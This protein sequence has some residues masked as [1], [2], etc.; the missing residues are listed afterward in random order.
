MLL[1]LPVQ[2]LREGDACQY[3]WMSAVAFSLH[4]GVSTLLSRKQLVGFTNSSLALG[5]CVC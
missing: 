1:T 5:P 3:P 4:S 2:Y